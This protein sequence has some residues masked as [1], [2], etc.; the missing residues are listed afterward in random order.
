MPQVGLE[1]TIQVFERVKT[2]YTLDSAATL[3]GEYY[4]ICS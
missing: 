2:F 1:P 4:V 3:S